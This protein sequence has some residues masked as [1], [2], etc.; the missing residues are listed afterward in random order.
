MAENKRKPTK[1]LRAVVTD[2]QFSR[3][4]QGRMILKIKKSTAPKPKSQKNGI[5]VK[6]RKFKRDKIGRFV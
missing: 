6:N 3:G 5:D 2:P 4:P 1:K